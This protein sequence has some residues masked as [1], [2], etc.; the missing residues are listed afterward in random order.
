M[1][2]SSSTKGGEKIWMKGRAMGNFRTLF[3]LINVEESKK[4]IKHMPICPK[5]ETF[6][7]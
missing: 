3:P 7:S 2:L 5:Q 1:S 4:P 6:P